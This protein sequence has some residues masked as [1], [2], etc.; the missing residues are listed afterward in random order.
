[1][2]C[3]QSAHFG[4]T[5]EVCIFRH[6][7]LLFRYIGKLRHPGA[8][9]SRSAQW[10]WKVTRCGLK[11]AHHWRRSSAR[12]WGSQMMWRHN[13]T[14]TVRF[15]MR[16]NTRSVFIPRFISITSYTSCLDLVLFHS[17]IW[18]N[19]VSFTGV[20][21]RNTHPRLYP[22]NDWV[23]RYSDLVGASHAPDLILWAPASLASDGL[24]DLAEHANSSKF[25]AEIREKVSM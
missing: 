9:V 7:L 19:Q 15:A 11:T 1:M 12:T 25:E 23:P 13:W 17:S 6:N 16:L 18:F 20:W 3:Q 10:W 2:W 21:S 24:R 22:E 4:Q 14:M 8:G 5:Y